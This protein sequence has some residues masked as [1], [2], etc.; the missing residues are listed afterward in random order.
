MTTNPDSSVRKLN[1]NDPCWCGS[2]K[3]YKKCHWK[4]DAKKAILPSFLSSQEKKQIVR[5]DEYV[6]GM[7][8]AC[9]LAKETLEMVGNLVKPGMTTND[10]DKIVHEYT[11]DHNAYP[12]PLNYHGFPKS[13]CTSL[14][15]VIC[16]GIPDDTVIKD[17]DILNIDVTSILNGY[18]GDTNRS[19]LV[20][21]VSEEAR[22]LVEVTKECLDLAIGVVKPY[23]HMGDIGAAIQAHA[24]KHG[25]SVVEK[26]VGHGIGKEFHEDPQVPHFGKAGTGSLIVPGMF[27]TIE[28]MINIG[29]KEV[30][31][32]ADGWTALTADGSLSAQFEH[33]IYVHEHGVKVLTA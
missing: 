6:E 29:H 33:T 18:H 17:G 12:A 13:V 10:I 1:R 7:E 21:N 24:H 28:P 19:F 2:Q 15:D 4:E 25:Y 5:S 3:K 9:I 23:C 20:G 31:I 8:A 26:F 32:L 30:R 22:K 27:F 11:L 14:N 16:H